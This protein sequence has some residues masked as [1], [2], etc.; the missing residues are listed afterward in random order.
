M[1]VLLAV[2]PGLRYPAAALFKDGLLVKASRIPIPKNITTKTPVLERCRGI[3][4]AVVDYVGT[5]YGVP[6]I[7]DTLVVEYP[8]VY[9]QDKSKGN[10][11]QLTPLAAMGGVL[12]GLYPN[13]AVMSPLPREWTGNVPKAEEGDPWKSPRGQ[14]VWDRLSADERLR[15]V[16]SHDSIDAVGLG[17]WGLGRYE[18]KRVYAYE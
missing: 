2:D 6:V 3:C 14:R 4:F 9:T 5:A 16:P 15:V 7:P 12:A 13:S 1:S 10:P 18:R 8:Q 11:N 17:L